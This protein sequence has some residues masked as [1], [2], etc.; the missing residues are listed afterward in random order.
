MVWRVPEL[1]CAQ[2]RSSR[3]TS[4]VAVA[5][6]VAV[7]AR[8]YMLCALVYLCACGLVDGSWRATSVSSQ[9]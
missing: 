5:V 1:W 2:A 7:K 6:T 9:V 3:N 4:D 8:G